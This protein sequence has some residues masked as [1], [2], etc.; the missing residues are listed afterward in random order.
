MAF[1]PITHPQQ[2]E[3]TRAIE[4]TNKSNQFNTTGRRW[5]YAETLDF[6]AGGGEI[7]AFR[8]VDKFADYGLVGVIYVRDENIIQFIMSCRVMGMEVEQFAL[9]HIADRMRGKLGNTKIRAVW[10][11][12]DD[13]SP[14]KLIFELSGFR[15][16]SRDGDTQVFELAESE[17][18]R[19]PQHIQVLTHV[20]PQDRSSAPA[21]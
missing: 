14:C 6:L 5:S 18:P 7:I 12:T 2:S 11:K 3:F 4:L 16:I 17:K 9:S 20:M 15:E 1:I 10:Q 8:V 21:I 19:I 13:N